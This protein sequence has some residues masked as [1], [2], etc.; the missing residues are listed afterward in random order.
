M[1]PT[2]YA[3]LRAQ[4][5]SSFASVAEVVS[6]RGWS[7]WSPE[8]LRR[9]THPSQ[10][11]EVILERN[12]G[13]NWLIPGR[14]APS[15]ASPG[16]RDARLT[17][18]A[19]AAAAAARAANATSTAYTRR[20]DGS[21]ALPTDAAGLG[22]MLTRPDGP[23]LAAGTVFRDTLLLTQLAQAQC[24]TVEAEKYRRIQS[25]CPPGGDGGCTMV[26]S[27]SAIVMRA[28][29]SAG[30]AVQQT[31]APPT[32]THPPTHH[33]PLPP[34]ALQVSLYWMA[35]DLWVAATKGGVEWSGR[36]KPLHYAAARTYAPFLVSPWT[37][38]PS[39]LPPDSAPFGVYL[40]AHPP[41]APHPIPAGLLRITCWAWATGRV[42]ATDV[43]IAVP[44]W[45]APA[46]LGPAAGGA[47]SV[48]T[49]PSLAAA[50]G[51]C[52]C[53]PAAGL[54]PSACVLTLDV[55]NGTAA[56]G[57]PL[58]SN[59]LFPTPLKAVTTMVDPGLAIAD[60]V[61]VPGTPG[62]FDVTLTAA[63]VPAAGVWVE[64]LLCCGHFSDNGFLLTATTRVLRYTPGDDARGWAHAPPPGAHANVTAGAFAASLSVWSLWDTAA[65]GPAGGVVVQLD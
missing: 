20:A 29:H 6:P 35:A 59:W 38:P 39:A 19:A 12:V 53:T 30:V 16:A 31:Q 24:V 18:A 25:E 22:P 40:S 2:P 55:Y 43:P 10:P 27:A 5:L 62:A 33:P 65:Y 42:G 52:G 32:P 4:S 48:H 44:A 56:D 34:R 8:M 57:A 37:R 61:P 51:A 36:W 3:R 14:G 63:R 17:G 15:P 47:L 13:M 11:P 46:A 54:P 21:Y 41:V 7:Y 50:L 58:G 23:G 60:V 28:G 49:A 64:S 26:S 9:D 45:P 1:S